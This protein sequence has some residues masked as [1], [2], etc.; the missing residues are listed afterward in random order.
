MIPTILC[1]DCGK[2]SY[3]WAI[4]AGDT[5]CAHCGSRN[6]VRVEEEEA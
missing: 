1:L 2:K 4:E 5:R 6:T 3:G